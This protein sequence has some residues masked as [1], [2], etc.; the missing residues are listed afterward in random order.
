M[1]LDARNTGRWFADEHRLF[2][3]AMYQYEESWEEIWL[4]DLFG[5]DAEKYTVTVGEEEGAVE[6]FKR[7]LLKLAETW[8]AEKLTRKRGRRRNT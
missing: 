3:S 4:V 5:S 1:A 6:K 8:R 2:L 7:R